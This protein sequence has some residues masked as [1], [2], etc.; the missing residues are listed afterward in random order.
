MDLDR[1]F[2]TA[3]WKEQAIQIWKKKYRS[4]PSRYPGTFPESESETVF[5][6]KLLNR[7]NPSKV[8]TI[9]VPGHFM[10][11]D[12]PN[13]LALKRF[14][15]GGGKK[16]M[17]LAKEIQTKPVPFVPGTLGAYAS[18]GW[19]IPVLNLELPSSKPE[20]A[21]RYWEE[22][23]EGLKPLIETE[24]FQSTGKKR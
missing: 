22:F 10:D 11:F 12:G 2:N 24:I 4:T 20:K 17:E 16:L 13:M 14:K 3:G 8:V 1:N 5:Q 7:I 6:T 18:E 21:I 23:E 9:H 15:D 19:G